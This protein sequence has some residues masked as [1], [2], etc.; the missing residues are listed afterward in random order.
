VSKDHIFANKKNLVDDFNFGKETARVFDDMLD[1]SVPFYQEVQR[2][3][4]EMCADFAVPGT[5]VYDLGCS[6]CNTFLQ[7]DAK[8]P[9]GVVCVGVDSSEEMLQKAAEK[10]TQN[11]FSKEYQLV[12]SDI[13]KSIVI[14]NA[15]VVVLNLTL[16][17]VRPLHREKVIRAIAQGLNPGGCL[18][19][20]EKVLCQ[21]STLNRFFIKYYYEM[22]KRNGYSEMEISQKREALENVLIPYH[23]D[24]NRDLLLSNGFKACDTFFR[25]YNFCGIVALK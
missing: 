3:I 18:I 4:G 20:V 12:H 16:Q 19:L 17:F 15:S 24:E 9:E 10:L 11:G 7:I 1:R 14:E 21:S 22:K 8:L 2:M 23:F 25:W 6:T 5:R 13:N